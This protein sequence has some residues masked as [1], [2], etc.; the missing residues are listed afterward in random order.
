M[1][2]QRR[3][4][5]AGNVKDVFGSI[6][7]AELLSSV[8][9]TEFLG[10]SHAQTNATILAI[11]QQGRSVDWARPGVDVVIV[12]DRTPFYAESGGQVGDTGKIAGAPG[13]TT[14]TLVAGVTDTRKSG[15][16]FCTRRILEGDPLDSITAT[17]D[18]ARR[19]S[20]MRNHTAT[21]LLQAVTEV[22][23]TLPCDRWLFQNQTDSSLRNHDNT[24]PL[25]KL[26]RRTR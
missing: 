15:G 22:L 20:I 5:S 2:R 26:A 24:R 19:L 21:H 14:C 4:S 16:I 1:E 7:V 17:V 6:G 23:R 11:L 9:A 25:Q 8:P 12:L 18:A 13:D 10:Y 3:L